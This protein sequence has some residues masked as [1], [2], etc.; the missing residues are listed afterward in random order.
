MINVGKDRLFAIGY[1]AGMAAEHVDNAI[2][3][4]EMLEEYRDDACEKIFQYMLVEVMR[5]EKLTEIERKLILEPKLREIKR[6]YQGFEDR[7]NK[8][9]TD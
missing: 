7:H 4:K 8:D 9:K 5:E 3:N 1:C 6:F 2:H